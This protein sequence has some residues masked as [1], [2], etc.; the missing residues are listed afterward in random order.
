[1]AIATSILVDSIA[2]AA[3]PVA[4]GSVTPGATSLLL[5]GTLNNHF[6]TQD[7]VLGGTLSAT[8]V[9][10]QHADMTNAFRLTV[11]ACANAAGSGTI[12]ATSVGDSVSLFVLEV[13]GTNRVVAQSATGA[14]SDNLPTVTLGGAVSGAT[15]GFSANP[16]SRTYTP[17]AG[18]TDAGFALSGSSNKHAAEYKI[19]GAATVNYTLSGAAANWAM[20]G[21]EARAAVVT[22]TRPSFKTG[23]RR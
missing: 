16:S 23:W 4:S 17:G 11:F 19:A 22:S 18:Y 3:S 10:V 21:L 15:F 20:V 2:M 13:T 6:P 7:S 1:M 14:G 12:T 8:W 5:A 9:K